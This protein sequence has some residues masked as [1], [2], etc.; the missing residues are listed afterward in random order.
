MCKDEFVEKYGV[1]GVVGLGD[2]AAVSSWAVGGEFVSE[3][4]SMWS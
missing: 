2:E 4:D 1:R 3:V